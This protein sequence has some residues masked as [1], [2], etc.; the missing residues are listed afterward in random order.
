MPVAAYHIHMVCTYVSMY[1]PDQC[2]VPATPEDAD[3]L[4]GDEEFGGESTIGKRTPNGRG[5]TAGTNCA[6]LQLCQ[7]KVYWTTAAFCS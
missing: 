6:C 5:K 4:P 1:Y 7:M 2:G 3:G